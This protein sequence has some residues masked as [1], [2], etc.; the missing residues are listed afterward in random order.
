MKLKLYTYPTCITS[1]KARAW[2]EEKGADFEVVDLKHG[3]TAAQ[4]DKL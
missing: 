3:L 1:K 4:L 2:L